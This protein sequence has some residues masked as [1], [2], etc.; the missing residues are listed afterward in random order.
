MMLLPDWVRESR[1][2]R[3]AL[4]A[5]AA[6]AVV[7]LVVAAAWAWYRS[8]ETRGLAAL[9]DATALVQRAQGPEATAQTRESAIKALEAVMADHPRLSA[10]PQ[11]AYQLG[12]LKYGAGQ[13]PAARGAYE[14]ALAK[15][16]SG[17]VRTLAGMGIGYTWEA[18]KNYANAAQAYGAAVKGLGRKDF[19]Y[20]EAL[21]AEARA[22][23][24][25][26]KPAVALEIY[27]RLLREVPD[28]RHAE[29]L[30]NRVAG[31]RGRTVQ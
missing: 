6:L 5:A 21:M 20:E 17:S 7:A 30:R 24:L 31:L 1:W 2:V 18:E 27:Q 26:G 14:L 19:L 23:E 11:V 4:Q 25:A 12:N 8:Q 9:A 28:S 13:Y 10:I 15:G 16:A 22:Q 29:D 3:I